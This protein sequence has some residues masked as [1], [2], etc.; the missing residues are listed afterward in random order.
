MKQISRS[1]S[2]HRWNL[3]ANWDKEMYPICNPVASRAFPWKA[4]RHRCSKDTVE[5]WFIPTQGIF[6]LSCPFPSCCPVTKAPLQGNSK[7][8]LITVFLLCIRR[9]IVFIWMNT[10]F[11]S[12]RG[13]FSRYHSLTSDCSHNVVLPLQRKHIYTLMQRPLI[14]QFLLGLQLSKSGLDTW[15]QWIQSELW[16][17]SWWNSYIR[18]RM[19]NTTCT[20]TCQRLTKTYSVRFNSFSF[21]IFFLIRGIILKI[22]AASIL[23]LI[24]AKLLCEVLCQQVFTYIF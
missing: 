12:D 8:V 20:S 9:Y 23:S 13:I 4:P 16:P 17:D 21:F 14:V 15:P 1:C 6:P 5:G 7:A 11:S 18:Q 10:T 3:G 19:T 22:F 24:L 2:K